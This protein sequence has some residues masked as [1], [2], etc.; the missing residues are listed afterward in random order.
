V[1]GARDCD[2]APISEWRDNQTRSGA[3]IFV[4]VEEGGLNLT[5]HEWILVSFG[6]LLLLIVISQLLL[7]VEIVLSLHVIFAEIFNNVSSMNV[8]GD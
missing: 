8:L 1:E 5:S 7:P 3:H 2:P 6:G 4:A